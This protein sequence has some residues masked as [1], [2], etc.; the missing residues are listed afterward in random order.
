MRLIKLIPFVLIFFGCLSA[1]AQSNTSSPYSRFGLGELVGSPFIQGQGLGGLNYGLRFNNVISTENPAS[2]TALDLTVFET[3]VNTTFSK[4][5]TSD[6]SAQTVN[7]SLSH[8]ALAFPINKKIGAAFGLLPFSQVGYKTKEINNIDGFGDATTVNTGDGGLNQFFV[9]ASYKVLPGLSAGITG[10][11]YFGS[12]TNAVSTEFNND[13]VLNVRTND[14]YQ[15]GDLRFNAGLQYTV[16]LSDKRSLNFGYGFGPET[17]LNSTRTKFS[18]RYYYDLQN[19]LVVIDTLEDFKSNDDNLVFP[20]TQGI[21]ATY[22]TPDYLVGADISTQG[23]SNTQAF[24]GGG[25]ENSMKVSVGVQ[26]NPNLTAI[27]SYGKLI[28]YRF[29]LFYNQSHIDINGTNID[30]K[31]LTFGMGLPLIKSRSMI[32]LAVQ[33]LDRG[34]IENN[35][36]R[37]QIVNVKVG[38]TLLDK[39]FIKRKYE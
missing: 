14:K 12:V 34:T 26:N 3:G 25:I 15:V 27:N 1:E 13:N 5:N 4:I 36:V 17:N 6:F 30:E 18:E 24:I 32:N 31:G 10:S 20:I 35:L 28:T 37:E 7:G 39:W 23:W 38:F 8:F 11:Y 2:L 16:D 21:G 19:N 29:G 9:A 22:V 33:Y